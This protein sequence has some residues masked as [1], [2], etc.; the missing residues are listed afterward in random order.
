[1]EQTARVN[2]PRARGGLRV[3]AGRG[4]RPGA[5][6]HGSPVAV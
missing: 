5:R 3:W 1:L 2:K 4:H 6:H